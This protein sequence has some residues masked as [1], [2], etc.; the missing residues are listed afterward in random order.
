[1]PLQGMNHRTRS[2]KSQNTNLVVM[3]IETVDVY[4]ELESRM[5][6]PGKEGREGT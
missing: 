3:L 2:T 4:S 6:T 1:M 5:Q